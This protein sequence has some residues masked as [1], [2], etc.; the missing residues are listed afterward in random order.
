M[1]VTS[2]FFNSRNGDRRYTATQFSALINNLINDGVF[3]NV[4]TA[5]AVTAS[6]GNTITVGIGRSWFNGI[7]LFNDS[8]LPMVA[9][10]S[11][12]LLDRIDAVVI[13]IN[14]DETVREGSIRFINGVPA[15]S[16]ERP[17]LTKSDDVNQYPLAYIYR[18]A[19]ASEI[20][21]ADITNMIGTSAC[22]YVNG[23]L[24]TQNI[25][26]IVAQWQSE[27]NTWFDSLETY[28][29]GD[30]A[31]ELSLRVMEMESKFKTLA[32]EK[33]IYEGLQDSNGDNILD[34]QGLSIEGRTVFTSTQE[35]ELM[36]SVQAENEFKVGDLKTSIRTDLDANWLL[37][38]GA[39]VSK[40]LYPEL[41]R[42]FSDDFSDGWSDK[43]SSKIDDSVLASIN[44]SLQINSFFTRINGKYVGTLFG[45]D[46]SNG[47]IAV[48]G[49]IYS[50]SPKGPWSAVRLEALTYSVNNGT[51]ENRGMIGEIAYLNGKYIVCASRYH[52]YSN[53]SNQRIACIFYADSLEGPWTRKDIGTVG[54]EYAHSIIYEEGRYIVSGSSNGGIGV[55]PAKPVIWYATDLDGTWTRKE[56]EADSS[57]NTGYL[58][59]IKRI[60]KTYVACG[61]ISNNGAEYLSVLYYSDEVDGTWSRT[62]INSSDSAGFDVAC[63]DIIHDG[64]KYIAV[65]LAKNS[66]VSVAY[67][68]SLS[69][70][71]T[72]RTIK[73]LDETV[74]LKTNFKTSHCPVGI[75]YEEGQYIVYGVAYNMKSSSPSLNYS[76]MAISATPDTNVWKVLNVSDM[77][78]SSSGVDLECVVS[79]LP[80]ISDAWA[81]AMVRNGGTLYALRKDLTE[82]KLPEISL[83]DSAYTYIKATGGR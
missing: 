65:G 31:V 59:Q 19:R 53:Y 42:F 41:S 69:G 52:S 67:G 21:Q 5:F 72:K 82:F 79:G 54:E 46:R 56:I 6:G 11:E 64:N 40:L 76:F 66:Y 44:M 14:N 10:D 17:A 36:P 62:T 29:E 38:N 58:F 9:R 77:L 18:K 78:G 4:G 71:F 61:A 2:G 60:N 39:S 23:I 45:T 48:H 28:L 80:V 25:D 32:R 13:E 57:Y 63:Y 55:G 35:T 49:L 12:L 70:P 47:K 74:S 20:T 1:S 8:L 73:S 24:E 27:F 30:V 81:T 37:C 15:S 22:P 75:A 3:A 33:A 7:W 83:A 43:D 68:P 26:K 34:S 51:Y 16:P 50:D